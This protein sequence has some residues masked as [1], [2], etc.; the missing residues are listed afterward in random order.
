MLRNSWSVDGSTAKP[1][2]LRSVFIPSADTKRE[3]DVNALWKRSDRAHHVLVLARA[4]LVVP[5]F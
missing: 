1:F 2:T 5:T 3:D 4:F